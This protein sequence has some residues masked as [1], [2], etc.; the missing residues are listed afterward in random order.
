MEEAIT[1]HKYLK[2]YCMS[3]GCDLFCG[4]SEIAIRLKEKKV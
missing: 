4:T 3:E 1:F 2:D